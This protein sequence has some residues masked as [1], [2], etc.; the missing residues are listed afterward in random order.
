M[1]QSERKDLISQF[2]GLTIFDNLLELAKE[3]AK[4]IDTTLKIYK[5]DNNTTVRL[6]SYNDELSVI[7]KIVAD[8]SGQLETIQKNR[9]D[10]NNNILEE[11]KKLKHIDGKVININQVADQIRIKNAEI[12]KQKLNLDNIQKSIIT[13]KEKIKSVDIRILELKNKNVTEIYKKYQTLSSK[14][15]TDENELKIKSAE[16]KNKLNKKKLLDK[17]EYDPNCKYCVNSVFVKD[18][19]NIAKEIESDKISGKILSDSVNKL[20]KEIEEISWSATEIEEY[21]KLN[22]SKNKLELELNSLEI[23]IGLIDK[24]ITKLQSEVDN[25]NKDTEEYNK[26]VYS[27]KYNSALQL[28][29]DEL[30]LKLNNANFE[31]NQKN[32]K[33]TELSS[34]ISLI[35]DH[36]S[37]LTLTL[38]T[39]KTLEKQH[40][41]YSYY[42]KSVNRDGLPYNII[43]DVIPT[44]ENELNV[45]LKQIDDFQIKIDIDDKNIIP[46]ILYGTKK[47]PIEMASGYERFISSLAIRVALTN[48]SNLP[49]TAGIICD[50]GFGVIDSNNMPAIQNFFNYLKTRYDFTI[51]IS[52]LEILRDYVD[53]QLEITTENGFS[54]IEYI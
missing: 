11:T 37:Q 50:E 29:I 12:V 18:A 14:L 21:K 38:E 31:I 19:I 49:K 54:K 15:L 27:V 47:W 34:K 40:E 1:G 5:T 41:A 42:L 44:V 48:I 43:C 35:K 9:D 46:H 53:K 8:E 36:I 7:S 45:I 17:H 51:I 30:K 3:K 24:L 2:I 6:Q 16:F 13:V 20:K 28:M 52:H 26:Q 33:I 22:D 39:I 10:L 23:S 4:T 25:L 32:K